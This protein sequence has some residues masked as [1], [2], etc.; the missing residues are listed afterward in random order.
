MD[1]ALLQK[2]MAQIDVNLRL[3]ASDKRVRVV[4]IRTLLDKT[5]PEFTGVWP[6]GGKERLN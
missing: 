5:M 3:K 2:A 6:L 1:K 4:G